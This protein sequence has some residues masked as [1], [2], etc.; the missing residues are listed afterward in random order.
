MFFSNSM[1]ISSKDSEVESACSSDNSF[2]I[3]ADTIWGTMTSSR[4]VI[5]WVDD[6]WWRVFTRFGCLRRALNDLQKQIILKMSMKFSSY[7]FRLKE[8]KILNSQ[9]STVFLL[10][11]HSDAICQSVNVSFNILECILLKRSRLGF[12]IWGHLKLGVWMVP[13]SVILDRKLWSGSFYT[14]TPFLSAVQWSNQL[15]SVSL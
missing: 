2:F 11:S 12:M 8:K 5:T 1:V 15:K 3:P 14:N 10:E 13:V 7:Y 6:S 9:Q 4:G